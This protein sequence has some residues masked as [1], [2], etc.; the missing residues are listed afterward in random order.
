M[1]SV[2][3]KSCMLCCSFSVVGSCTWVRLLVKFIV[4]K[5]RSL[6]SVASSCAT[7]WFLS[8]NSLGRFM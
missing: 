1:V 4:L 7:N 3:S 5:V 8:F 2:L 6:V